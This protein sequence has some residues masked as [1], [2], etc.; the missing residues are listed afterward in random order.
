[1]FARHCGRNRPGKRRK[2]NENGLF[3]Y[4]ALRDCSVVRDFAQCSVFLVSYVGEGHDGLYKA[5]TKDE[6]R[7]RRLRGERENRSS[8]LI[9]DLNDGKLYDSGKQ[10]EGKTFH[11]LHFLGTNDDLWD[12]VRG[13]GSETWK[14]FE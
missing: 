1:M 13:L 8:L 3:S 10:E 12:K 4:I 9:L 7:K 14:G 11:K 5:P 2:A 6:R